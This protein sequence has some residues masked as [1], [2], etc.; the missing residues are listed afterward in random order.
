MGGGD[1][2]RLPI[3]EQRPVPPRHFEQNFPRHHRTKINARRRRARALA[4]VLSA[5]AVVI[6]TADRRVN[7]CLK[8]LQSGIRSGA[9]GHSGQSGGYCPLCSCRRAGRPRL[10]SLLRARLWPLPPGVGGGQYCDHCGQLPS[11][12]DPSSFPRP[13]AGPLLLTII[14]PRPRPSQ[15]AD[16]VLSQSQQRLRVRDGSWA[17]SGSACVAATQN[18]PTAAASGR[19]PCHRRNP[20]T[21]TI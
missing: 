6:A 7:S 20:T 5:S 3:Q 12:A 8:V 16:G 14:R 2:Q 9:S 21:G 15:Q 13:T 18:S 1:K 4:A 11:G 19:T 17:N 10:R